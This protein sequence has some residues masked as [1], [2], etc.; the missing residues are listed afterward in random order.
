MDQ[1]FNALVDANTDLDMNPPEEGVLPQEMGKVMSDHLSDRSESPSYKEAQKAQGE[2]VNWQRESITSIHKNL[3]DF[4]NFNP[5][6]SKGIRQRQIISALL[7][8]RY[9]TRPESSFDYQVA[10]A[11]AA[12]DLF[13]GKG[14]DSDDV[15]FAQMQGQAVTRQADQ[16]MDVD[17]R[18][19]SRI[20]LMGGDV[21]TFMIGRQKGLR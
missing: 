18:E 3:I 14:R 12:D 8:V 21:L 6:K 1:S 9:D 4:D 13:E 5:G 7:D 20:N 16:D 15:F 11:R 2:L 17:L 10:R 19:S